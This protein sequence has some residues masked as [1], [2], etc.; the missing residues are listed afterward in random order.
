MPQLRSDSQTLHVESSRLRHVSLQHHRARQQE[1]RPGNVVS[2]P[3]FLVK[4]MAFGEQGM[5]SGY[6][7][8]L[9]GLPPQEAKGVGQTSPGMA[10]KSW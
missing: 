6:I 8:L 4:Q 9:K 7:T 2:I 3:R 1:K 5:S 10:Y